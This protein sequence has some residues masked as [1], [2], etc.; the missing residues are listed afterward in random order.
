[1]LKIPASLQAD[2]GDICNVDCL[3]TRFR[4]VY[5]LEVR[6]KKAILGLGFRVHTRALEFANIHSR[7]CNL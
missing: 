3:L 6:D 7:I 1:M 4:L 2:I 5:Y